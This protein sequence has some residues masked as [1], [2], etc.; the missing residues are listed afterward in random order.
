MRVA[1]LVERLTINQNMWVRIPN[2]VHKYK[3]WRGEIP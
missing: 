1:Q 2:R 3:S